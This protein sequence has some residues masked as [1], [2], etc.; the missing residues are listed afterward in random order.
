[1]DFKDQISQL[2]ERVVKIKDQIHTEESTKHSLVMPFIQALGYDIFNPCEVVP[3]YTCDI[4]TK[5]GEK[6]DYA[7]FKDKQPIVLIECKHWAQNLVLHD[8]QLL[9]YFHVSKA[10]SL[11]Y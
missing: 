1:M 2:C 6:I 8:N 4:G 10:L 3:E 9:R 7:I 11:A 5:K